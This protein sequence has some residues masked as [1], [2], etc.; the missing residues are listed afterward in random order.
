[1]QRRRRSARAAIVGSRYLRRRH[2]RSSAPSRSRIRCRSTRRSIQSFTRRA[3]RTKCAHVPISLARS[4]STLGIAISSVAL[5]A[6]AMVM[7][8]TKHFR[9]RR[10]ASS[11]CSRPATEARG[12]SIVGSYP[13]VTRNQRSTAHVSV[14]VRV[15]AIT[16]HEAIKHAGV[17]GRSRGG[18]DHRRTRDRSEGRA[19]FGTVYRAVHPLITKL[20]ATKPSKQPRP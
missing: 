10:R 8:C 7:P 20:V 3:S 13:I 9:D 14:V 5:V 15:G 4:R 11:R 12:S 16:T 17:R 18:T 2:P 1:M 6:R 19:G